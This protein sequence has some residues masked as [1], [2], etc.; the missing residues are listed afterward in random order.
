MAGRTQRRCFT[1]TTKERKLF[2][3]PWWT[4]INLSKQEV[5]YFDQGL[6]AANLQLIGDPQA[7]KAHT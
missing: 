4:L 1:L 3:A 5:T 7:R 2:C 6:N